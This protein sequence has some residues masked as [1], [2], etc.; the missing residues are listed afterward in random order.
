MRLNPLD[1][2]TL[3]GFTYKDS[4]KVYPLLPKQYHSVIPVDSIYK[5]KKRSINIGKKN[6]NCFYKDNFSK[7]EENLIKSHRVCKPDFK[8]DQI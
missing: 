8:S 7:I 3:K 5:Y 6:L 1:I 4:R 2:S